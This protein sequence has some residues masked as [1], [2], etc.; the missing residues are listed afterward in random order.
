MTSLPGTSA[1]FF[2]SKGKHRHNSYEL[3]TAGAAG[4]PQG[5][6]VTSH[7]ECLGTTNMLGYR[8]RENGARA[9][10][11]SPAGCFCIA[12]TSVWYWNANR[13]RP[14]R[15]DR[16]PLCTTTSHHRYELTTVGV[17]GCSQGESVTSQD[18]CL[19]A[20]DMID[21]RFRETG[22][23]AWPGSLAGCFCIAS[24]GLCYLNTNRSGPGRWDIR[25]L[26]DLN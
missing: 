25:P 23:R 10:Y 2:I 8:F 19:G 9:W 11:G 3:T 21:Y 7:G 17:A 24:N 26:C 12:S 22:A 20:T 1:V 5:G 14:G 15:W 4:C 13:R 16:R 6:S 18:E